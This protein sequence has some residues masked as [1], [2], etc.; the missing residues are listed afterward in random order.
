MK[1]TVVRDDISKFAADAIVLPANTA[2][3][4]GSGTSNAIFKKAGRKELKKACAE[5]SAKYKKIYVGEAIPTLAYNLDAAFII[6]AV[7]PK[8][9]D[10]KHQEYELLSSAYYSALREADL[11]S[12]K[13]IAIPLLSSGNN[14]F[15]MHASYEMAVQTI[16]AYRPENKL[17][18]VYLIV[19]GKRVMSMLRRLQVPVQENIDD[20]YILSQDEKYRAPIIEAAVYLKNLG[21]T[22]LEDNLKSLQAQLEDEKGREELVKKAIQMAKKYLPVVL[23][24]IAKKQGIPKK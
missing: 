12:C 13:T 2:L 8:W 24:L 1:Y 22:I 7:T 17:E 10:G 5:A 19:Y 16:E 21:A 9:I 23:N 18:M 20:I 4:E 11:L 3:K 6:H 15:D 14:G